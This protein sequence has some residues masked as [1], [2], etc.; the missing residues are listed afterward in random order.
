MTRLSSYFLPTVKEPPADAEAL[1]HRLLV[2]AGMIRQ[3]AS[4]LWT[5]LPAGWRV[6]RK[7]EQIVREEMDAIGGQEMLMPVMH[8]ADLWRATGRYDIDELFKLQD[9][10]GADFVL[11]MTH[12]ESVT[13]HVAREVRS[14]RDLPQILYH[15]QIKERDE[16]RPRAGLLRTREFIMKDSYTFDRDPEGLDRAYDLHVK[17]YDRMCD[18]CGLEWY[19]VEA[20]V[21][22]MGGTG[23]H[24]YM[25]PCPAGENEVALSEA[26]Y[27]ANMEIASA[28]P[29]PVDGL[30][31]PLDEPE[32]VDTPGAATIDAVA[33]LL[34]LPAGALLKAMPVIAEGRGPLL[35]VL[36]GD[37]RLNE[38]KLRNHLRTAVRPAHDEEIRDEFGTVAGFIGPV[39]ARVDVLAD[40]AVRGLHGLVAGA[41][42]PDRHL[43]GVEPGRDFDPEWADVRSVEEGDRCPNGAV[44]RI[45]P[46]IE[47]GNI[48]KL[49]TRY[50]EPLGATYLDERG[51][52]QLIWMGSFGFGPARAMA[53]AV[54]QYA[55]EHGIS[56]PRAIAPFDAEL[57][58]LGKP[59]EEGHEVAERLY[60]ELRESELE[61]L[62]DD[63]ESSAGEKFA[64]AEL[65]GCPLRL[66]VGKRTV[67]SGEVEAQVRRGRETQT[68]P[69]DRAAEAVAEL[70]RELP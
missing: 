46:A 66:T 63:R 38:F 67:E 20:D 65:V 26:G 39:G 69:L 41:N 14:Y 30:L 21:G 35:V 5:F 36:R 10:R 2:R 22:M 33:A 16:P 64:D 28:E 47:V 23:A 59:G 12:E 60:G 34:G 61:V 49:G 9:R 54:E 57:V 68:L 18:R 40:E 6:H 62:Y 27:A 50:S 8:P 1:S 29:Q 4:G 56:W 58:G 42:E 55:D 7:V 52:E 48:F 31:E 32:R 15:F 25:A 24:E 17:A 37:H 53:A 11:A 13:W 44:I 19:R 45:E 3:L 70:W 43:R 51:E